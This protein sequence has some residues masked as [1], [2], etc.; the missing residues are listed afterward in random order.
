[1]TELQNKND[2]YLETVT[3]GYVIAGVVKK[4]FTNLIEPIF[5]YA[6]YE[7]IMSI[8]SVAPDQELDFV[9]GLLK[10]LPE[11]NYGVIL[12]MCTF[13]KE[14]VIRREALNKMS[15][16]NCAVVFAPCF[17]RPQNYEISDLMCSGKLVKVLLIIFTRFEEVFGKA[18]DRMEIFRK[19]AEKTAKDEL[20]EKRAST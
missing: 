3:D 18:A 13:L 16:Y 12:F 15:N 8:N 19:S 1:M 10:M 14:K 11:L 5:P 2:K 4:M 9:K 7:R 20:S 17:M 6:V